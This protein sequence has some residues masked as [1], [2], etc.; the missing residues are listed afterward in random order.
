MAITAA[1]VKT[2]REKTG[3][4]LMD[5]KKALSESDG[6]QEKAIELL[7]K[8]GAGKIEKMAGR[9][10][11]Q[12]RIAC[13]VDTANKRAGMVALRC[14][15]APV[16]KTD[17]F[18]DLANQMARCAAVSEAPTPESILDESLV[19]DPSRKLSDLKAEV[20]NRL[21]ENIQVAHV[22]RLNGHIGS[23]IHHDSQKGAMVAFNGECPEALANGICMHVTAINPQAT[24]REEIDAAE[25]EKERAVVVESVKDKPA[26]IID[27]IVDGKMNKWFGEIALLEQ[28]YALDDK[29]TVGEALKEASADL[30]IDGF[31][32]CEVGGA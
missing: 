23:Y 2:L 6:D 9:E 21:R 11:T 15:T 14:E 3:L 7:R 19:D 10:T 24:R 26:A 32:R 28:A 4:P 30:T 20:F 5:C 8:K 13:F 27:K 1:M 12:G 17:D 22:A 25:V 16:A 31:V 18:V 29:K